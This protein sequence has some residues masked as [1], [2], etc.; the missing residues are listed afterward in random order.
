MFYVYVLKSEKDH[1]LYIGRTNN[2]KRRFIE[3]NNGENASTK[4]RRPLKLIYC[5]VYKSSKDAT[6]RENKL[7][8]FKN[9]YTEL[10]KRIKHSLEE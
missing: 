1:K 4:N 8:Q 7:K 10:K 9:S 2:I 3:H 6:D 5:E